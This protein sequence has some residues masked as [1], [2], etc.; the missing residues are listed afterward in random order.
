MAATVDG[1]ISRDAGPSLA[2]ARLWRG[3]GRGSNADARACALKM[4][5]VTALVL[6]SEVLGGDAVRS[7]DVVDVD[8]GGMRPN[9]SATMSS[10]GEGSAT[11]MAMTDAKPAQNIALSCARKL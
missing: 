9:A 6:P 5:G 2:L 7:E 11:A 10:G 8:K 4:K 1:R 3:Q